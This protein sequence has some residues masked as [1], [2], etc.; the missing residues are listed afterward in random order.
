MGSVR[1]AAPVAKLFVA[2][3]SVSDGM[4]RGSKRAALESQVWLLQN[5]TMSLFHLE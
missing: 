1:L 3:R 5:I 2:A 4:R